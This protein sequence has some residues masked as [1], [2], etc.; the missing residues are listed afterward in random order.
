MLTKGGQSVGLI[1]V[2]IG[3]EASQ[4]FVGLFPCDISQDL[5]AVAGVMR[6]G[7]NKAIVNPVPVG[8]LQLAASAL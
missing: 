3:E 1:G 8:A 7:N 6:A 5:G 4:G 2:Q